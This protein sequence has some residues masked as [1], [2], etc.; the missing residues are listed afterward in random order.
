MGNMDILYSDLNGI[1]V[2]GSK[3]TQQ[4]ETANSLCRSS[5]KLVSLIFI[6]AIALFAIFFLPTKAFALDLAK[7]IV[8][9]QAYGVL[10]NKFA[11]F[12]DSS[13]FTSNDGNEVEYVSKFEII[14]S[15][16]RSYFKFELSDVTGSNSYEQA[17]KVNG[18]YWDIHS[19]LGFGESNALCSAKEVAGEIRYAFMNRDGEVFTD[20]IY[21]DIYWGYPNENVSCYGVREA[22]KTVD[23][24]DSDFNLIASMSIPKSK[25]SPGEYTKIDLYVYP[26]DWLDDSYLIY[27]Y[28]EK[29]ESIFNDAG[30]R[31]GSKED[32]EAWGWKPGLN[33]FVEAGVY[34]A[35]HEQSTSGS[36]P[37]RAWVEEWVNPSSGSIN[38]GNN[39]SVKVRETSD[40]NTFECTTPLSTFNIILEDI[41]DRQ[42]RFFV[43]NGYVQ[44]QHQGYI[45]R[46]KCPT[47][48]LS[49]N[50]VKD[51]ETYRLYG[52]TQSG[53]LLAYAIPSQDS[54]VSGVYTLL[55][56]NRVPTVS[57][58]YGSSEPLDIYGNYIYNSLDGSGG[59][60]GYV[61]F[62][63]T[64]SK[65]AAFSSSANGIDDVYLEVDKSNV[66]DSLVMF[67]SIQAMDSYSQSKRYIGLFDSDLSLISNDVNVCSF[68]L[69]ANK[70]GQLSDGK[71]Y[72][73]YSNYSGN[74]GSSLK[75]GF[76]LATMQS[77]EEAGYD[78]SKYSGRSLKTGKPIY[79]EKD[80]AGKYGITLRDGTVFLPFEYDDIE[81]QEDSKTSLI[82][83]K[84]NGAWEFFD[85]D[86]PDGGS[87]DPTDSNG[88]SGNGSGGNAS[89]HPGASNGG[90][91]GASQNGTKVSGDP[92]TLPQTSDDRNI[93]L[94]PLAISGILALT[95][96]VIFSAYR[97]RSIRA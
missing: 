28:F 89:N 63:D 53:Q 62:D 57:L 7:G 78:L 33:T 56:S 86:S 41:D 94:I 83:L 40:P 4:F 14:D 24:F 77:V 70:Y 9:E 46:Y 76:Y 88:S 32:K 58:G 61:F 34:S 1:E 19:F 82:L 18:A 75:D 16:G 36:T 81:D 91:Q 74:D 73:R 93:A 17:K 20:Y 31:I 27:T 29:T 51:L 48:D 21:D 23:V 45:D 47:W 43:C 11:L 59:S 60:S 38:Y 12:S 5:F 44:F 55:N 67:E 2:M 49:G 96:L 72:Y 22:D 30:E 15:S 3:E 80:S 54:S 42:L 90:G 87:D 66:D 84:K 85:V 10:G 71:D 50:Y 65:V 52:S 26:Y 68:H 13:N 25:A 6:V 39:K 97:R 37:P 79:Y 69:N 64:G 35:V 95:S 8:Y 92:K